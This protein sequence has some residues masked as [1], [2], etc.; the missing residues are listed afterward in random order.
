MPSAT[1]ADMVGLAVQPARR[2]P[3]SGSMF[4][5][6][7]VAITTCVADGCERLADKLLIGEG[8]IGLGGVEEGDAALDERRG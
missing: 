4:Q 7:L 5:P 6:N 2:S 3:V 1:A 8:A